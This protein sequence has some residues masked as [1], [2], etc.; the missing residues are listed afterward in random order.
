MPKINTPLQPKE[1]DN[2]QIKEHL[3]YQNSL[4]MSDSN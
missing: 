4:K 3:K 1:S 2:S